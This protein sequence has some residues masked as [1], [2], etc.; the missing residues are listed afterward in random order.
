MAPAT[1]FRNLQRRFSFRRIAGP[2]TMARKQ[3]PTAQT[4]NLIRLMLSIKK[5]HIVE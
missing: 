3:I 4:S 1:R 2:P 5:F